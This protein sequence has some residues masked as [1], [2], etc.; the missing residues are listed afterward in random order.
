MKTLDKT[1]DG[2]KSG[3]QRPEGLVLFRA[4]EGQSRS[5]AIW[6]RAGE[7]IHPP[8]PETTTDVLSC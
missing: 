7:R 6:L 2:R 8:G 3:A 1:I 5:Q 4:N